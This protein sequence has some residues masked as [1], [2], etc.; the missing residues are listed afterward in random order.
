MRKENYPE[1][2]WLEK[3]WNK[4]KNI[5][6]FIDAKIE[7]KYKYWW[8][9]QE[10]DHSFKK[11]IRFMERDQECSV[12]KGL[13]LCPGFNDF[14]TRSPKDLIEWDYEKNAIQPDEVL[15][16]SKKLLWWKC[17][18]NHSWQTTT[19]YRHYNRGGCPY[20]KNMRVL[21]DFNDLAFKNPEL[22]KEWDYEKNVR[23]PEETTYCSGKKVHWI[24]KKDNRH[25][26]EEAPGNRTSCNRNWG[27]PYCA[28]KRV[29]SG[30]N[31]FATTH[32]HLLNEW[33]YKKNDKIGLNPTELTFGTSKKAYWLCKDLKHSWE[34]SINERTKYGCPICINLKVL[35]GYN[36]FASQAPE[37]LVQEW[38]LEKNILKS[39]EVV[40]L[41]E[42]VAWWKCTKGHS[43][44]MSIY[45]RTSEGYSCP[46][47][48]NMRILTGYND[49]NF[50]FPEIA[51]EWHPTKNGR[52]T[53]E[54]VGAGAG[55]KVW[56][57]CE[58]GHSFL[59]KIVERTQRK[60]GC[61]KC[62]KHGTS[63]AEKELLNFVQ[64]LIPEYEIIENTREVIAPK[65]L[66][67]YIPVLNLA[68]EFNGTYW[69]SDEVISS[70]TGM[71]A[72]EFHKMKSDM[73]KALGIRLVHVFEEDWTN[74]KSK[75][76]QEIKSVI[77][78]AIDSHTPS[79]CFRNT[80]KMAF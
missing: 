75:V 15:Y 57:L 10:F 2:A 8:F 35:K 18:K 63:I 39:D 51:K 60:Y 31:D 6:E 59:L 58:E 46:I 76:K 12:C 24:C 49:L 22:L 33:D 23:T 30:V 14:K 50:L 78:S 4:E 56:W 52:L 37:K 70:R 71:S 13:Q 32:P 16:R 3:F 41:S 36:D 25:K 69:H 43:Y 74:D 11:D 44:D 79:Q 72:D 65:E 54:E 48:S 19:L 55:R 21:K 9:C 80:P 34:V 62:S 1:L 45:S 53:P 20:C 28:G 64:S 42:K 67:I 47:C 7:N 40:L 38:D 26:W 29:M 17:S 77:T 73:C 27:C 68:F 61:K 5:I 66:D